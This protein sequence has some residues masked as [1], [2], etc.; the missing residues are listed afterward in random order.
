MLALNPV[1]ELGQTIF[2]VAQRLSRHGHYG[3][4]R[5]AVCGDLPGQTSEPHAAPDDLFHELNAVFGER[6]GAKYQFKGYART[7]GDHQRSTARAINAR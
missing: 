2:D 4:T 3:A 7:S 6:R 1:H 5:Q